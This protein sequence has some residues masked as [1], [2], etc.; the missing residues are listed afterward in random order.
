VRSLGINALP[1]VWLLDKQ[2][3]LRSLNALEGTT[4]QVRQLLNE[5]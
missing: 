1:T 4:D 3:K 5:K 2:G